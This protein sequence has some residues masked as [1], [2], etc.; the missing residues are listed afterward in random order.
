MWLQLMKE[1][2]ASAAQF[3]EKNLFSQRATEIVLFLLGLAMRVE[4]MAGLQ[5]PSYD[6]EAQIREN[7]GT[8]AYIF[9]LEKQN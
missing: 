1:K 5:Q 6:H 2:G 4:V 7:G 8:G 3:W 9:K